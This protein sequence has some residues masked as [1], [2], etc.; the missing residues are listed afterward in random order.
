VQMHV[1]IQARDPNGARAPRRRRAR[2]RGAPPASSPRAATAR[3]IRRARR[4]DERGARQVLSVERRQTRARSIP[5]ANG[6][7][8]AMVVPAHR[9]V[10]LQRLLSRSRD[11]ARFAR[12]VT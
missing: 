8:P 4:T 3:T 12:C 10:S 5:V 9:S 11:R 6:V 1:Q 7:K 2:A